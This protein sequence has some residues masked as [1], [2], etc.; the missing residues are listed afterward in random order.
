MGEI[1]DKLIKEIEKK[2]RL[3]IN[4]PLFRKILEKLTFIPYKKIHLVTLK[5]NDFSETKSTIKD[6]GPILKDIKE[7]PKL[8]FSNLLFLF[9]GHHSQPIIQG[10]FFGQNKDIALKLS[11]EFKGQKKGNIFLFKAENSSLEAVRNK[12][13]KTI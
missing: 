9:E 5:R 7:D 6:I 11:K 10:L 1:I 8:N 3:D 4:I 13:L 12:I 2:N